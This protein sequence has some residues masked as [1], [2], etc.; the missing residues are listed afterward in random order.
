MKRVG[1]SLG[2]L[3]G[4]RNVLKA[5]VSFDVPIYRPALF[6]LWLEHCSG[7]EG[8]QINSTSK[9]LS[10]SF[11]HLLCTFEMLS[12][13]RSEL[14]NAGII[15]FSPIILLD[16]LQIVPYEKNNNSSFAPTKFLV[17]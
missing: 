7:T 3:C 2:R 8:R 17:S 10:L 5:Q 13:S 11:S 12:V 16:V 1:K 9:G 14:T 15:N 6:S 4:N